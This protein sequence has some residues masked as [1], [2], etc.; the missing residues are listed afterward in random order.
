ME[1]NKETTLLEAVVVILAIAVALQSM[2]LA[3]ISKLNPRP[4]PYPVPMAKSIVDVPGDKKLLY[5]Q[6]LES[7]DDLSRR[8]KELARDTIEHNERFMLSE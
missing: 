6:S 8:R 2:K 7:F 4:V 5:I 1:L 3:S